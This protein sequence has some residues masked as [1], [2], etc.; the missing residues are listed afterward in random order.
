MQRLVGNFV[1]AC[2]KA[3]PEQVRGLGGYKHWK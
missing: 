1:Q 2:N 3:R